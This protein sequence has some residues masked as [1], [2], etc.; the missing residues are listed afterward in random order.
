M[1]VSFYG[2]VK[3]NGQSTFIFDAIYSNRKEMEDKC[4]RDKVFVNRYVLVDYH[5]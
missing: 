3:Q 4:Q 2:N 1:G 5:Y